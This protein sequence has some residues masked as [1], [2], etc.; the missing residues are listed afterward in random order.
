SRRSAEARLPTWLPSGNR[1]SPPDCSQKPV[2]RFITMAYD[3]GTGGTGRA[4]Q[5][6]ERSLKPMVLRCPGCSALKFF[7]RTQVLGEL[8]VCPKCGVVFPWREAEGTRPG[9]RRPAK[10]DDEKSKRAKR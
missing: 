8:V 2:N 4:F 5:R 9:K 10:S 7:G 3:V 1:R 6:R